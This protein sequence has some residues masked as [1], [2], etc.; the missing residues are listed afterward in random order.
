MQENK[1]LFSDSSYSQETKIA[2]ISVYDVVE[3][4][5]ETRVVKNIKNV[6]V[7]ETMALKFSVSL[8]I[9]RGYENVVFIYDNINIDKEAIRQE[10]QEFFKMIQFVWLK[11][12]FLKK[13]DSCAKKALRDCFKIEKAQNSKSITK[14]VPNN[15]ENEFNNLKQLILIY[16]K[17]ELPILIEKFKENVFNKHE[18]YI[19]ENW[20]NNL[21]D[22]K[23]IFSG[24]IDFIRYRLF[25]SLLNKNKMKSEFYEILK[26]YYPKIELNENFRKPLKL[27]EIVKLFIDNKINLNEII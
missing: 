14:K 6:F 3:D 22:K 17:L 4:S 26:F 8:A 16:K 13:V 27:E 19:I 10:Y 15:S 12:E 25:Y 1:I 5:Y 20:Q 7:A 9:A 2:S 18:K 24:S 21:L 11:R 23:K